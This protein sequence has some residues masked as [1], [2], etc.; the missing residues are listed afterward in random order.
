MTLRLHSFWQ[1]AAPFRVRIGLQLKGLA[2]DYVSVNLARG[3]Q[4]EAAYKSLNRQGLAPAL[5][6]EDRILTQSLAILEWLEETHP[7]PP[8]LPRSPFDRAVVRAMAGVVACDIHPINNRRVVRKLAEIG[9]APDA[10]TDWTLGWVR[11]GFD[12]LEPMIA[13]HGAGY[14]FGD[15]PTIAD[16]CIVPQAYAATVRYGMDLSAWPALAAAVDTALK[17][18]A[19]QAAHPD[20]QPDA[21]KPDVPVAHA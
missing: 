1:A 8:L 6:V 17:T 4:G 11:D 21:P 9:V 19:F 14:A 18:P 3:E 10:V 16:C 12:A 7:Q 5:E 15:T 13:A 20:R 2:Y